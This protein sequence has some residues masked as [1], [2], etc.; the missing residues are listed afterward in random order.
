[1]LSLTKD[2]HRQD[3]VHAKYYITIFILIAEQC[4][5]H[6]ARGVLDFNVKHEIMLFVIL[7]YF[8]I[9]IL[10][11]V[12]FVFC[13]NFKYIEYIQLPYH[14]KHHIFMILHNIW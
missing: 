4:A 12:K 13:Y 3:E 1:M 2:H 6:R 9:H 10:C 11:I 7:I 14:K 5:Y 8:G